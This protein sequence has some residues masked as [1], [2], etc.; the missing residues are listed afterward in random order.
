MQNANV[1]IAA[2]KGK[3]T[4]YRLI[5]RGK[6]KAGKYMRAVRHV[7]VAT[8]QEAYAYLAEN[9]AAIAKDLP[10]ECGYT[11]V[12]CPLASIITVPVSQSAQ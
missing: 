4:S 2:P 9:G 11:N 3:S 8:Q 7:K 1:Q 10:F 5:F 12:F 6:N